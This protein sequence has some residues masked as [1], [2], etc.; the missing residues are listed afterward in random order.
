MN[1]RKGVLSD[2]VLNDNSLHVPLADDYVC[3]DYIPRCSEDKV[4]NTNGHLLINFC[5]QA[6]LIMLNGRCGYDC[7]VR[8]YTFVGHF[9]RSL[10]TMFSCRKICSKICPILLLAI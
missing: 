3:D 5:K 4:M 10:L 1:A 6:S 2:M 9:G 7:N 8:K